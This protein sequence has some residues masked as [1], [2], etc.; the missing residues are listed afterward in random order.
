LTCSARNLLAILVTV[1]LAS[2]GSK[3]DTGDIARTGD[4]FERASKNFESGMA[5]AAD[6]L[7]GID[8]LKLGQLLADNAEL[9]GD[10]EKLKVAII[11]VG[12]P[13]NIGISPTSQAIFEITGYSGR[14][15]VD[16]WLDTEGDK[17]IQNRVLL[18]NEAQ[19]KI[20][21]NYAD[22]GINGTYRYCEKQTPSN[23]QGCFFNYAYPNKAA[24]I[25][26]NYR[27]AVETALAQF[28]AKPFVM[29][30][31]TDDMQQQSFDQRFH[32]TGKHKL[33]IRITPEAL[34]S[35]GNWTIEYKAY[36]ERPNH[37]QDKFLVGRL[38]SQTSKG[39]TLGNPMEAVLVNTFDVIVTDK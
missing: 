28:L 11:A 24:Q 25:D 7:K 30:S 19:L 33:F 1:M 16:A 34:D 21:Y 13:G 8:P 36:V 17:F 4:D 38:D 37:R 15:R 32:Q 23:V 5:K 12:S 2:C 10:V 22:D 31:D 26:G 18:K 29:P 3:V 20:N 39:F 9:R 14:L 6:G 35:T 27:S